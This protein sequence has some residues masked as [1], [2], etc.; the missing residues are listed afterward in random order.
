MQ[1]KNAVGSPVKDFIKAFLGEAEDAL[2]EKGY[3][4]CP[5]SA[6]HIKIELHAT[7]VTD[8]DG[9]LRI[10][11]FSMGSKLSDSNTQKMT[12]YAKKISDVDKAEDQARK[13]IAEQKINLIRGGRIVE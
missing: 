12:I 7:E 11:V 13:K 9:G 4:S 3:Q 5:E 1:D 6:S 8:V 2:N 10:H